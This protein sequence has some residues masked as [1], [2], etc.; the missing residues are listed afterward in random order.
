MEKV[1]ILAPPDFAKTGQVKTKKQA[2]ADGHWLGVSNIWI[3]QDK[4]LPA[5]IYQQRSPL[6]SWGPML[7]DVTVGGYY[8]TGETR[9]DGFREIKEELG[10]NYDPRTI[11][12]LGR[13]LF[14]GLDQHQA[15]RHSVVD[16]HFVKDNRS[17]TQFTLQAEEVYALCLC[18]I[19]YLIKLHTQKKPFQAPAILATGQKTIISVTPD[20]IPYNW[21]NY[22]FKIALLAKRFLR[23]EK[24]LVY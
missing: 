8:Q 23:G 5:I 13:K 10:V 9:I 15:M 3:I 20:L 11:V 24:N 7:L 14:F 21:D 6:S 22:H 2:V 12:Y 17:L 16:V 1:D 19:D 4:P 18:P